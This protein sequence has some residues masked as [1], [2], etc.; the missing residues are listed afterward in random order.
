MM[1]TVICNNFN[2]GNFL[3][4]TLGSFFNQDI[5]LDRYEVIIVD[6]LS[7][8]NSSEIIKKYMF[9]YP[10]I[11]L[12]REKDNGA[13]QGA[14][15]AYKISKGKIIT[16]QNSSDYF[17]A[18]IFSKVLK[19]FEDKDL[20]ILG[21]GLK[22]LENNEIIM[23]HQINKDFEYLSIEDSINFRQSSLMSTF[24][25]R[26]IFDHFGG[27]YEDDILKKCHSATFIKYF[28]GTKIFEKK[29]KFVKDIYGNHTSHIGS[30]IKD[31]YRG[32]SLVK[33]RNLG[34]QK[35]LEIFNSQLIKRQKNTL[36]AQSFI[37][38]ITLSLYK[39]DIKFFFLNT[40]TIFK[41]LGFF[42][43]IRHLVDIFSIYLS[44]NFLKVR[45]LNF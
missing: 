18:N 21:G 9:K 32:Y 39:R 15:K 20:W 10:N 43:S 23:T 41:L 34:C 25:K 28:V 19:E 30:N 7:K 37:Y 12:I 5:S 40:L 27:F 38:G 4:I 14:N 31:G 16:I 45:K 1:I 33:T 29:I 44:V 6:A 13:N 2:L 36:K 35:T 22:T 3:D 24:F 11:K 8:D 26:D 17:E 42:K